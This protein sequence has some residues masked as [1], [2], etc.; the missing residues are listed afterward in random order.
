LW[1]AKNV[2]LDLSLNLSIAMALFWVLEN[3]RPEFKL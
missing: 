1:P 2:E 3:A